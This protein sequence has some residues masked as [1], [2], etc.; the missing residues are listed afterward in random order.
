MKGGKL[1]LISDADDA[2][3]SGNEKSISTWPH[4]RWAHFHILNSLKYA[5][6]RKR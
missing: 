2:K 6:H 3:K 1:L 4:R 5:S